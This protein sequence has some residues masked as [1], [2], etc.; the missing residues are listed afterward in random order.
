MRRKVSAILVTVVMLIGS[1]AGCGSQKGSD[2]ANTGQM[3]SEGVYTEAH[4]TGGSSSS[5]AVAEET[6][7][8]TAMPEIMATT[9][10]T[11]EPT[12]APTAE[13]EVPKVTL[14]NL[15]GIIA[16]QIAPGSATMSQAPIAQVY[17]IDTETGHATLVND[18]GK[19]V[20]SSPI[21]YETAYSIPLLN[22][23]EYSDTAYR[24]FSNDFRK[25]AVT[26]YTNS[27]TECHGDDYAGWLDENGEFF[28]VSAAL[29][30]KSESDFDSAQ[31]CWSVGFMDDGRFLFAHSE[32]G[33]F[34]DSYYAVPV[35][36]ITIEAVEDFGKN[37]PLKLPYA[38]NGRS[39]SNTITDRI[40]ETHLLY[41]GEYS[42][43]DR[44][45]HQKGVSILNF[46][47]G[48]VTR[49][50]P[51]DGMETW[52]GILDPTGTQL[53]FF[54]A[55]PGYGSS[56]M[57]LYTAPFDASAAPSQIETDYTMLYFDNYPYSV[58]LD[59]R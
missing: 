56:T 38:I 35:D 23:T 36:N 39:I 33:V 13:P 14:D 21:L 20:A 30:W 55:K 50:I 3:E 27:T 16:A 17:C 8:S 49:C 59:W 46:E 37:C 24:C 25:L 9:E 18:F 45:S 52:N 44:L 6:A 57:G 32:D 7:E 40:D 22:D 1:L 19:V 42:V 29:G 11:P 54:A 47:T 4:T 51:G 43:P 28:N 15:S 53:V 31:Y 2:V 26:Y 41:D 12:V 34:A 58:L 48:E 5:S 10:P